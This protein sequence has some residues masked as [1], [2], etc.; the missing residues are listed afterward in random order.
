[1]KTWRLIASLAVALVG[2]SVVTSAAAAE[3]KAKAHQ[4]KQAQ[5]SA[6]QALRGFQHD[7]VSLLALRA[8]ASPLLAAAEMARALS[9]DSLAA[10]F[11]AL[12]DRASKAP[13]SGPYVSW[14]QLVNCDATTQTCPTEEALDRLLQQAPDNAAGWLL[15]LGRD[16]QEMH[17]D[18]ARA[19]LAKAA[20]ATTYDDYVGASKGALASAIAILPPPASTYDAARGGSPAG[21]VYLLVSSIA[22]TLPRPVLPVVADYCEKKAASDASVK[23]DCLKLGKVLE[24]GSSPLSRSLGLHLRQTLASDPNEQEEAK[25]AWNSLVWQVQNFA[26]LSA[27]AQTDPALAQYLL[28]LVHTGGTE[29]SLIYSALHNQNIPLDAPSG[30]APESESKS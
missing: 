26:V 11:P 20:A 4:P 7:L 23:A 16:R 9:D 12:L 28:G 3:H 21:V 5:P 22:E 29:M 1:M 14:E 27:K 25:R 10:K 19:D 8:E 15:K 6:Q 24:W 30:W 13:G 2:A 17:G 18:A